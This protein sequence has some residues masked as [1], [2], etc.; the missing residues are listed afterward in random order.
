ML[1]RLRFGE[2]LRQRGITP[3]KLAVSSRGL[4]RNTVYG[5]AN[6]PKERVRVDLDVLANAMVALEKASGQPVSIS[7]VLE[8]IEEPEP[9]EEM[10]EETRAWMDAGL[11]DMA[12]RLADIEKDV[13]PEKL[14]A[15]HKAMQ[16]AGT[17]VA[18]DGRRRVWLEGQ[19]ALE[20]QQRATR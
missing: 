12:A 3:N 14:A 13:P 16:K 11:E 17:P 2:L 8:V 5:L 15:W 9:L 18:Y 1:I 10:D 6:P 19:A 20:Y 4:S 7:D